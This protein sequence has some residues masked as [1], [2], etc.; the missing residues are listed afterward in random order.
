MIPYKKINYFSLIIFISVVF[1]YYISVN[2]VYISE[3][4]F[5]SLDVLVPNA[6]G[7]WILM[8]E[9][10]NQLVNPELQKV[11]DATYDQTL[12][13][14]YVNNKTGYKIMVSLAYGKDQN[15]ENTQSHRPEFCYTAQG[16][17][18]SNVEKNILRINSNS[19]N[20]NR[21]IAN[22]TYRNEPI[23]YWLK[24]GNK[25]SLPGIDRKIEQIIY[26]L[27]GKIIDGMIVRFSSI[28]ENNDNAFINQEKFINDLYSKLDFQNRRILFGELQ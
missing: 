9:E 19:I 6:F 25:V 10:N 16:F 4:T 8:Q 11:I 12:S 17:T 27:Q 26:G 18:V 13:K 24:V 20:V 22:R 23:T 5:I 14:T 2:K 3:N 28:D 1:S 21:I 7:D 15:S